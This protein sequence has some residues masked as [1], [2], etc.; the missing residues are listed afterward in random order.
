MIV[1]RTFTAAGGT[2]LTITNKEGLKY[3]SPQSLLDGMMGRLSFDPLAFTRLDG[4]SQVETL[5]RLVGLDFTKI[6]SDRKLV[7]DKRTVVNAQQRTAESRVAAMPHHGDVTEENVGSL[8]ELNKQLADA[9]THNNAL[10]NKRAELATLE[11]KGKEAADYVARCDLAIAD[12]E[13]K[14]EDA[15]GKRA[16]GMA[17]Q[18]GIALSLQS[19]QADLDALNPV[20][21]EAIVAD[22]KAVQVRQKKLDENRQREKAVKEALEFKKLADELTATIDRLDA[23]KGEQLAAAKF[24]VTGL[25]FSDTGVLFNGIPLEQASA[26]EKIRVSVAIGAALNP[27]VRVILVRDGSLLDDKSLALLG[28]LAAEHKLQV[29]VERVGKGAECSVIMEDGAIAVPAL[30]SEEAAAS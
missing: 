21:T 2:S 26:A 6:D 28:S 11:A 27:K 25:T 5:R 19:K 14:L 22:M 8:E 30:A 17:A 20:S 9:N 4:K 15:K 18:A 1:K 7:Y 23:E 10:M 13:K 24:P 12:L 29:W 3:P 16:Q